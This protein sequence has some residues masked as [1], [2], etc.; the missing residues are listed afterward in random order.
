MNFNMKLN[1][2][3]IYLLKVKYI[4]ILVSFIYAKVS[5]RMYLN[6]IDW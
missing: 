4:F 6:F 2:I 3:T 5:S 1:I